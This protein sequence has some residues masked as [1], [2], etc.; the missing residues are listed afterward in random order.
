M[1][2]FKYRAT[3]TYTHNAGFS[4]AFRQWRAKSKC[5]TIHGY[6]L[7][8]K[9]EFGANELDGNNWSLDFGGL[10][11]IKQ[12]LEDNF[13][14]VVVTS[15]DDPELDWFKDG[16]KRGVLKLLLLDAVGCE[17]FAEYMFGITEKWLIEQTHSPRVTLISVEV[18]EHESNSA[19]YTNPK[20]L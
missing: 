1:K 5:S 12:L 7:S 9:F 4:T 15:F 17:K 18:R 8:F 14:H 16:E 20:V 11:Y 3:K 6:S 10:K 19:I 13:D 2:Q